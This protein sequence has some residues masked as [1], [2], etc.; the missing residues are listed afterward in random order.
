MLPSDQYHATNPGIAEGFRRRGLA[1]ELIRRS[2]QQ[3]ESDLP[4]VQAVFLHVA[5][6]QMGEESLRRVKLCEW[7]MNRNHIVEMKKSRVVVCQVDSK[8]SKKVDF[9]QFLRIYGP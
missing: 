2:V 5:R 9:A 8:K 4:E 3:V 7:N 1:R 6:R